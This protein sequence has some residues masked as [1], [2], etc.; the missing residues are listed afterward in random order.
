M[1]QE[2]NGKMRFFLLILISKKSKYYHYA[3][4]HFK[5][6]KKIYQKSKLQEEWTSVV[7]NVRENHSRKYSFIGDFEELV[8]GAIS[9]PP[10]FLEKTQKQWR[11][12]IS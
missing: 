2:N 6:A 7:E 1:P 8:K 3:L 10:S 12:C 4:N 9:Q 11:K 5:N